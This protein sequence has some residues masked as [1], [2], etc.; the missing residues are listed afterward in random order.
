MYDS[1]VS[2]IKANGGFKKVGDLGLKLT[3]Y[4]SGKIILDEHSDILG[5]FERSLFYKKISGRD[6]NKTLAELMEKN[7][8]KVNEKDLLSFY[9][10]HDITFKDLIKKYKFID[11]DTNTFN[12]T[13][14]VSNI[15]HISRE[16]QFDKNDR[17]R[18]IENMA[19]LTAH[20]FALSALMIKSKE[21][22]TLGAS[23]SSDIIDDE[24]LFQ[25]H[26]PQVLSIALML[27]IGH[28]GNSMSENTLNNC[29][30]Q[31]R[32]GEGKSITL[33][34]TAIILALLGY[35]V[36]CV[37]YSKY[38][39]QRDYDSVYSLFEKLGLTANIS[40][41]TF[42]EICEQMINQQ[43]SLRAI[44]DLY[45][46]RGVIEFDSGLRD[47]FKKRPNILL[48]D[49]VDVFFSEE[50]YGNY[51][52]AALNLREKCISNILDF[53]W[54]TYNQDKDRLTFDFVIK[55]NEYRECCS[56]FKD[57]VK[58]I[59]TSI[60]LI[61]NDIK[62]F[63]SIDHRVDGDRIGYI[64]NDTISFDI[65]YGYKTI[66]AYYLYE[67]RGKISRNSLERNKSLL[68]KL[69][70]FSLAEIPKTDFKH[71]LGVTGTLECL[72]STDNLQR[73]IIE[74][75]YKIKSHVIM[76]SVYGISKFCFNSKSDVYIENED[77]YYDRI[78]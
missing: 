6:I 33:S 15:S 9:K 31:I 78:I 43:G 67:K 28:K 68:V 73:K 76:P 37:C 69:G 2:W 29:L 39:S 38:L 12:L 75:D 54:N 17:Q 77:N 72:I 26:T 58:L 49:E 60:L 66:F 51:Y 4:E 70:T 62:T 53:I 52:L 48:I 3:N 10:I 40:Y 11:P 50:F 20:L 45:I 30:V 59:D 18:Y 25:P 16:L 14:L 64:D 24:C 13:P 35:D 19:K 56:V 32:T 27:N 44:G 71:I 36:Y 5:S 46:K 47:D 34:I 63:E 42:Y 65:E 21:I 7:R 23:S 57:W 1:I 61:L 22:L 8:S 41:G 74:Q 55:S